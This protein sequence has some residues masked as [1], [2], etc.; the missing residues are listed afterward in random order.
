MTSRGVA[1]GLGLL[2]G[3]FLTMHAAAYQFQRTQGSVADCAPSFLAMDP[4]YGGWFFS[5]YLRDA[6]GRPIWDRTWGFPTPAR[7]REAYEIARAVQRQLLIPT[8]TVTECR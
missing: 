1:C 6:A 2:L 8:L 4:D 3:G 5:V 7:C